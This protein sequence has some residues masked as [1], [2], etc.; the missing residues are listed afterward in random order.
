MK[1]ILFI[2]TQSEFGGAQRAFFNIA[3]NLNKEKYK[4]TVAAGPEG[5]NEQGFCQL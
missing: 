1:K 2:I 3:I 5:D 4:I